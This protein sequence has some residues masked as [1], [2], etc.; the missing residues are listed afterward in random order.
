M[1]N[2]TNVVLTR[3]R[4]LPH[5]TKDPE[6]SLIHLL[7]ESLGPDAEIHST[8][9]PGFKPVGADETVLGPIQEVALVIFHLFNQARPLLDKLDNPTTEGR[10]IYG[11]YDLAMTEVIWEFAHRCEKD[12]KLLVRYE[13]KTLVAVAVSR[14]SISSRD[15]IIEDCVAKV[16]AWPKWQQDYHEAMEIRRGFKPVR[17][18]PPSKA[19]LLPP[20]Y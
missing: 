6:K 4:Q 12:K 13:G 10:A 14:E 18:T 15:A 1:K 3:D 9:I 16:A 20:T 11:L 7:V 19:P 5:P 17:R 8:C 2:E